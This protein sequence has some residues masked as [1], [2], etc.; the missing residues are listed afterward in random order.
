ML[1]GSGDWA[2][3]SLDLNPVDLFADEPSP[4]RDWGERFVGEVRREAGRNVLLGYSL[5]GRLGLHALLAEPEVWSAAI[6]VSV[7]PGLYDVA[8]RRDRLESDREWARKVR[9][10]EWSEFLEEWNAQPVFGGA[11]LLESSLNAEANRENVAKG[12][13]VWSLGAQESL[14][15][16]FGEL[17]LPVLWVTGERDPKFCDL[18]EEAVAQLPDGRL[19]VVAGAGHRVPWEQPDEFQSIVLAFLQEC[20]IE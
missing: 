5:G 7:H 1:G 14:L 2:S 11:G 15:D 16:R 12:F 6:V 13:E 10:M 9:D 3:V 17:S 8:E 20:G 19:S 18:G 4:M